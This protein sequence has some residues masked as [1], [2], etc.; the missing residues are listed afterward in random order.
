[1]MLSKKVLLISVFVC[2]CFN[3]SAQQ[4]D[5]LEI[6]E[7]TEKFIKSF[8]DFDWET[9]K[10]CFADNATIFFPETFRERKMG[11]Q[12]IEESW[13]ELFPEFVDKNKKFDLDI[14]PEDMVIQLFGK[15][16]IVT[17]QMGKGSDY[18][19]RR[20]LV[21]AKQKRSWKIVHLHASTFNISEL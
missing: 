16:A 6:A 20:T 10:N 3:L 5:S 4:K 19:S 17:F 2:S 11:R 7:H 21:F 15:T 1:M 18:L 8:K 14:S 13:K 9:F 12:E